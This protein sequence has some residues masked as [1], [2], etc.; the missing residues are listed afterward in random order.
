MRPRWLCPLAR[1]FEN[2]RHLGGTVFAMLMTNAAT[3]IWAAIILAKDD[4][5]AT[6][7]ARIA[8]IT[9]YVPE[10]ALA[11]F[12]GGI[13]LFEMLALWKWRGWSWL[14]AS[15]YGLMSLAWSS[16]FFANMLAPGPIYPQSTALS[17]VMGFAAFFAFLDGQHHGRA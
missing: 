7:G 2:P 3:L 12:F 9:A 15:G 16:I 8:F 13:A 14:V 17:A 4:A 11:A 5:L 10:N 1:F 6:S